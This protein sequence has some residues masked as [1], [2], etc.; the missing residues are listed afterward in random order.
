M[1]FFFTH[2]FFAK[3]KNKH[4]ISS[5]IEFGKEKI[6]SSVQYNNVIGMQFHPEKSGNIGLNL[7]KEFCNL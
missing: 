7:L 3:P 5:Y 6:C 2:S 1:N 4:L